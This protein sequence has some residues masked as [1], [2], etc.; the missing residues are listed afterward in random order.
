[1]RWLHRPSQARW[2]KTTRS[3]SRRSRRSSCSSSGHAEW[4][5][6]FELT[7][8][9]AEPVAD[10]CR[11]LD[12]LPLGIE[13]AAARV[14][15]LGPSGVRDRLAG[16]IDL[17]GAALR[18]TPTRQR[19]LQATVAWSHDLLDAPSRA[20]FARMAVFVGGLPAAGAGGRVRPGRRAWGR[21]SRA[22]VEPHRPEPGDGLRPRWRTALR[23]A[24]DDPA[25]RRRAGR[26]AKRPVERASAPRP[27][28][29]GHRRGRGVRARDLWPGGGPGSAGRRTGEPAGRGPHVDRSWRP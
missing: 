4:R 23:D 13:L 12:G 28:V 8:A 7:A 14:G 29:P 3:R 1:M 11:R 18:D 5:P 24:R 27:S 10:I 22:R 2:R 20:L 21:P 16:R 19:T 17:P 25:S 9:N 6:T 15:L 26:T